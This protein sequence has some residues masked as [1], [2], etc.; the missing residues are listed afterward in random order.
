MASM[1]LGMLNEGGCS[2]DEML[3][4]CIQSFGEYPLPWPAAPVL[5]WQSIH[6]FLGLSFGWGGGIKW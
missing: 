6:L 4:K 2:E 3:E 5:R 1:A